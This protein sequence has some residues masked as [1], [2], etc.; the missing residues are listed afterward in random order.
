MKKMTVIL[1]MFL[2][3]SYSVYSQPSEQITVTKL[4]ENFYR[5]TA[6]KPYA[7][8]FLAYISN[9]GIL[10]VD[11]GNI[12]TGPEIRNVLKTLA[13]ENSKIKYLINT[14]AHIDH[15]GGNFALAGEPIIV[16]HKSLRAALRAYSYVLYEFPDAAVP[17]VTFTDSMTI[18]FGDE[19]I[20]L[21]STPG[22]HDATDII[23]HF[24]KSGIV[25]MGDISYG[26]SFPSIDAY[27]GNLLK[28]PEVLDR[29][30][31]LIPSNATIVSGHGRESTVEELKQYRDMIVATTK[32]VKDEVNKGKTAEALVKEDILKDWV[33]FEG[34]I[35]GPREYWIY[36]LVEAGPS[37]FL[38][39]DIDVMH[40]I[41]VRD[42]ADVAIKKYREMKKNQPDD[43]PYSAGQ[44][45]R[46]ADWLISKERVNEGFKF[47][48]YCLEEYKDNW[49]V[50]NRMGNSYLKVGDKE[51]AI[52]SFEKALELNPNNASLIEKIKETK[53]SK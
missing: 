20:R 45:T 49:S 38:G 39:S 34:G 35:G 8:N 27:T 42:N 22:S 48:D 5:L 10:L 43:Y 11:A 33:S 29:V 53:N 25:C 16:G 44:L 13:P 46:I 9:D 51:K 23:V 7:T 50:Y 6:L 2:S 47:Y 36:S 28:Y 40:N 17:A 24:V 12:Q 21:I 3:I 30:I 4:K 31:S 19:T 15:T 26:M 18:H 1:L 32:I 41:L 14:H 37:K 52:I